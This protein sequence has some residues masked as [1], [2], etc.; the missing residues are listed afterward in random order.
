[1]VLSD[2]TSS[3]NATRRALAL[4]IVERD[5]PRCPALPASPPPSP[6][7]DSPPPPLLGING[8]DGN[9]TSNHTRVNA[10]PQND[11]LTDANAGMSGVLLIGILCGS[12]GGSVLCVCVILC[13]RHGLCS[14]KAPL[15]KVMG[16]RPGPRPTSRPRIDETRQ[17]VE[18]QD[19]E[20]GIFDADNS[21][22]DDL[23]PDSRPEVPPADIIESLVGSRVE[24]A[25]AARLCNDI[26]DSSINE[27]ID[28]ILNRVFQEIN[29][30]EEFE[31][32][33]Q[34]LGD[35]AV[36]VIN[37]MWRKYKRQHEEC[38]DFML[39]SSSAVTRPLARKKITERV[40][41]SES[42][43]VK[44]AFGWLLTEGKD[45]VERLSRSLG[46]VRVETRKETQ[47][48]DPKVGELGKAPQPVDAAALTSGT[49]LI[50]EELNQLPSLE[51]FKAR[52]Q[53]FEERKRT[54][55]KAAEPK[56]LTLRADQEWLQSYVDR[57]ANAIQRAWLRSEET[58]ESVSADIFN[59]V[60]EKLSEKIQKLDNGNSTKEGLVRLLKFL[61]LQQHNLK[62]E[63]EE[64]QI[65]FDDV[66]QVDIFH[67]LI[68]EIEEEM[69]PDSEL[70]SVVSRVRASLSFKRRER[71]KKPEKALKLV[72]VVVHKKQ[73]KR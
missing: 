71:T 70:K 53:A 59:Q 7:G 36:S 22:D 48:D 5:L 20:T 52:R 34:E 26:R 38:S 69:S 9:V 73:T 17:G 33:K 4:A 29:R 35:L 19:I 28:D 43:A 39:G 30:I 57:S 23:N 6:R 25:R 62:T 12:I 63:Q 1:M 64:F 21:D 65:I 13:V 14:T 46:E 45:E 15:V 50:R 58:V 24:R 54:R 61:S 3:R 42:D 51:K 2:A 32:R 11:V 18:L 16:P 8:R 40:E 27:S 72:V 31:E 10:G 60:I 55:E 47:V 44:A 41:S 37:I 67:M 56:R 49:N 68:K 66:K